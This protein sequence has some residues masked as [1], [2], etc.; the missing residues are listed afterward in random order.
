MMTET[1]QKYIQTIRCIFCENRMETAADEETISVSTASH[2]GSLR[3]YD[4]ILSIESVNRKNGN[5]DFFL[6]FDLEDPSDED[7]NKNIEEKIRPFLEFLRSASTS[8]KTELCRQAF[9]RPLQIL[10][11]CTGGITSSWIASLMNE[12]A[13]NS[14]IDIHADGMPWFEI[15]SEKAAGYDM[16]LMAPQIAHLKKRLESE[17]GSKVALINAMDFAT[18]N[19]RSILARIMNDKKS[20]TPGMERK[21]WPL[22][23]CHNR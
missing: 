5:T 23:L 21:P 11:C 13:E 1:R 18:F 16:I 10:L 14:L 12:E 6:H 17:F 3:F 7:E 15:T 2:D 9:D 22:C 4:D 8:E 20:S 19:A